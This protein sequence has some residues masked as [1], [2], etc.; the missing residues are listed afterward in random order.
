MVRLSPDDTATLT[1]DGCLMLRGAVPADWLEP[2]RATFEANYVPSDKWPV[3]RGND[4]RHS[5]VDLDPLVQR[6]CH[7][8]VLSAASFEILGEPF[9][10]SQVEG[11]DPRQNNQT[12]ILHRD[13][14]YLTPSFAIAFVYLDPFGH[15]ME[16]LKS[17]QAHTTPSYQRRCCPSSQ[18]VNRGTF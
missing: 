7:L 4:W 6:V 18:R 12:Q 10:L 8:P 1:R 2:L 9:F 13:T 3:P 14:D 15:R 5:L 11:R 17:F 16:R